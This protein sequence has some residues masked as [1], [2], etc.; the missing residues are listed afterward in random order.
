MDT[1]GILM[2]YVR[3]DLLKG[4]KLEYEAKTDLLEA[5]IVDSVGLMGL[6]T[7]VEQRFGIA[8]PDEDVIYENFASIGA[9]AD[10]LDNRSK[11]A[12]D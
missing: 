9:L 5:G 11:T 2:E 8:V 3:T 7:F 12:R 4:R 6:V 1:R 10:Y